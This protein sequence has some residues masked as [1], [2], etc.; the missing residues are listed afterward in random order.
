LRYSGWWCTIRPI[1]RIP[2]VVVPNIGTCAGRM[3]DP[4]GDELELVVK[5][6]GAGVTSTV[7]T[8]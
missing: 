7:W 4:T 8:C 1:E 6:S 3:D 2:P 5:Q